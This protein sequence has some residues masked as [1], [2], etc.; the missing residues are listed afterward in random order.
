MTNSLPSRVAWHHWGG[1]SVERNLL[2][3]W[4]QGSENH[5]LFLLD[6]VERRREDSAKPPSK[7]QGDQG[8][9]GTNSQGYQGSFGFNPGRFR[10]T[11]SR[12]CQQPRILPAC[13][14]LRKS[15]IPGVI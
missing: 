5:Q 14:I 11:H 7:S 2:A 1:T 6:P 15:R 9:Q 8:Y 4:C 12:I 13:V 3:P 10:Q